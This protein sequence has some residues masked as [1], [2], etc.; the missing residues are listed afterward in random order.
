MKKSIVNKIISASLVLAGGVLSAGAQFAWDP[1]LT[2][3]SGGAGTWNLTSAIWYNG[4]TDIRWTDT[5]APGTNTAV[6]GGTA[7]TVTLG[8]SLVASNLVFTTPGYTL[9]GTGPLT[10]GGGINASSLSSGTTT[11]GTPLSLPA[12]QQLWQAGSGATLAVTGALTRSPGASVDFTTPGVNVTSPLLAN[13][14]TGVIGG[15]ATINDTTGPGANWAANDGSG[16]I[17]AYTGYTLVSANGSTTQN[18]AGAA[19][20]NWLTGAFS[21]AISYPFTLTENTRAIYGS[22]PT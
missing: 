14:A 5:A 9:S 19:T 22:M 15:W 12:A 17:I 1:G 4:A 10:L 16:N 8:A 21:N 6:F 7:G 11:I 3:G 18:G 20:Q 13:D 2:G